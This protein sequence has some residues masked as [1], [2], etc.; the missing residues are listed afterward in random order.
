MV[1]LYLGYNS[2]PTDEVKCQVPKLETVVA[3]VGVE[4]W[5]GRSGA[6]SCPLFH[7]EDKS[8]NGGREK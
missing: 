1:K 8:K 4:K 7:T 2:T 6:E 3:A 5:G